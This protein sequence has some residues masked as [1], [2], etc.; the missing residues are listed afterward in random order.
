MLSGDNSI[1]QKATDAKTL[2]G[3]QQEKEIIALAYN[4]ALAKKVGN[5]DST[6]VTSE[7]MNTELTNQGATASGS[8][9]IKVT[10]NA[11]KR[12]YTINNDS[13][14]YAGIQSEENNENDWI[15]AWTYD[16]T[17][18]S[19]PKSPGTTLSGKIIAKIYNLNDNITVNNINGVE[20]ETNKYYLQIIG[21]GE[22]GRLISDDEEE[23]YAWQNYYLENDVWLPKAITKSTVSDGIT[24]I[25]NYCFYDFSNLNDLAYPSNIESIG[26]WAFYCCNGVNNSLVLNHVQSIGDWAFSL[27]PVTSIYILQKEIAIGNYAFMYNSG[28]TDIYYI[29]T[30]EEYLENVSIGSDNTEIQNAHIHYNYNS[31]QSNEQIL[32]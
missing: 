4:S 1:L 3:I 18:W 20:V 21:N 31:N 13:I 8:N 32:N 10:F 28:F 12:K 16:G 23:A 17:N 30:E 15:V 11:S 14:E 24:N 6:P 2:T 26:N 7:D 29:G 9:P 27:S 5:G 25:G 22:M 19:E